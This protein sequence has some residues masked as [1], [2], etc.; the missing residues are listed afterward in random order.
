MLQLLV[1]VVQQLQ[2]MFTPD[3]K[4]IKRAIDS[5]IEVKHP[6]GGGGGG[7]GGGAGGAGGAGVAKVAA[8]KCPRVPGWAAGGRTSSTGYPAAAA[9][10]PVLH[11]PHH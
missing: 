3:V 11:N 7:G 4:V 1:E 10:P 2:R 8:C 9:C 6:G 5:L